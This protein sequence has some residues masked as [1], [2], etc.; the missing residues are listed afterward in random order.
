VKDRFDGIGAKT[1]FGQLNRYVLLDLLVFTNDE[2][3]LQNV[4]LAKWSLVIF[5]LSFSAASTKFFI[6]QVFRKS[7]I[8]LPSCVSIRMSGSLASIRADLRVAD[9]QGSRKPADFTTPRAAECFM[10]S[11]QATYPV[12]IR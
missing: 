8:G 7:H 1:C 12:R 3:N 6:F 11:P 4:R 9:L 2:S 5:G 10:L